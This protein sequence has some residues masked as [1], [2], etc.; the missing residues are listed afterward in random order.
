[1]I[2]YPKIETLWNRDEKTHKVIV[3]SYRIPEFSNIR[4]W[5][6]SEKVDG[7]NLRI[8]LAPSGEVTFSG[9]TDNAQ[10]H[11][12]IVKYLQETF[13][14]EKMRA[15]FETAGEYEATL[16]G[17]GYGAKIQKSG[18]LYRKGVSFRLFDV[19]I[20]RWWLEPDAVQDIANK[21]GIKTVPFLGE[22]DYL[23]RSADEL[24]TIID[25][26]IVASED[27]G[28]GCLAEGVV[29]RTTPLLFTRRGDRLMWKLKFGDF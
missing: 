29:A 20:G 3:G 11:A 4:A 8:N 9:R 25:M 19:L 24:R 15:V 7:T 21:L 5:D 23:P 10:L 12:T 2:H 14:P 1:M 17:E 6:L 28:T 16:F 27:G 26:S 18:G 13:T 22:V